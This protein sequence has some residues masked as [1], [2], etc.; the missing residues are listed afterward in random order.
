MLHTKAEVRKAHHC[1][2]LSHVMCRRGARKFN[3][4]SLECRVSLKVITQQVRRV[5]LSTMAYGSSRKC[6]ASSRALRDKDKVMSLPEKLLERK[7]A[8]RINL[9]RHYFNIRWNIFGRG[10][11]RWMSKVAVTQFIF[12]WCMLTAIVLIAWKA[13]HDAVVRV[14]VWSELDMSASRKRC[15]PSSRQ[16]DVRN[17]RQKNIGSS[18]TRPA[19]KCGSLQQQ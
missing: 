8:P 10:A 7:R 17:R 4:Y 3:R 19:H 11:M 1:F 9:L 12:A 18:N 2:S 13:A 5:T 15:R 14:A 16:R 6:P